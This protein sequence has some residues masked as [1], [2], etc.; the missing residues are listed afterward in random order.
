[1][2]EV[3]R[4]NDFVKLSYIRHILSEEGIQSYVLD[5]HT[6]SIDGRGPMVPIRVAVHSDAADRAKFVLRDVEQD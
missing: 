5:E 6:A 1:M 3:F 2:Q 4:T